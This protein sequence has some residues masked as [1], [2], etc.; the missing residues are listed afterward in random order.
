MV[1]CWSEPTYKD[2]FRL[3]ATGCVL[4]FIFTFA[5]IAGYLV[6]SNDDFK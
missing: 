3:A 2:A 1:S 4:E 6:R 5:G